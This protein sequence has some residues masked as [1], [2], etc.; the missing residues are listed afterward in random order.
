[1][2]GRAT[3]RQQR[4][5][6][7]DHHFFVEHFPQR[8]PLVAIAGHA[9]DLARGGGGQRVPQRGIRMDKRGARQLHAHK[10]NHHLVGVRRPVEVQVPGA[11]YEAASD[12]SRAIRSTLP[13]AYSWRMRTFSLLARPLAIGP[14]G[15][16]TDGRW[17]KESAA[18]VRPGTIFIAHP[19]VQRAVEHV[20]RQ[21]DSGG[22]GDHFAAQQ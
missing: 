14:D 1:M 9:G 12:S 6:A 3:G 2:V 8:H 17:P 19:E 18:M 15:I 16:K 7:V 11:W 4:H 10:L 20:M 5:D 13:S 21:T 22:H